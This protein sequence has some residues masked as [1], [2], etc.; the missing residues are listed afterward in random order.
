MKTFPTL[1]KLTSTGAVQQWKIWVDW[2]GN[3]P[4]IFTE[5]GQKDG[6][7]QLAEDLITEGK[8]IGKVNE[9]TP[10]E[11]A[12]AEAQS[13]WEKKLKKSYVQSLEDAEQKK[14]DTNFITGGADPMLAHTY[15][16]QGHKIS[17]PCFVQPKL[18]GHRCIAII[19]DG[20]CTLWSRTR[21][22]ITGVPHINREL[23]RNNSPWG[24]IVLD[25]ELYRHD[26]PFQQLAGYIRSETPKPGSDIVEYWVY[27]VVTEEPFV[28]RLE[29]LNRLEKSPPYQGD[30]ERNRVVVL[31]TF[32]AEDKEDLMTKFGVF[33]D[34]GY[35]GAMARNKKGRYVGKRSYDL[36]KIKEFED[37][38]FKIVDVEEGRG[39]M[40]GCAIFVCETEKGERFNAKMVGSLDNLAILYKKRQTLIGKQV[41]VKFFG[42]SEDGIPRFPVAMRL[43]E[44]V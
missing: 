15:D 42:W 38:E 16:K 2:V 44:D 18:D 1:Y 22:K 31:P 29:R 8:N 43:R 26:I 13:Q 30:P 40:A 20:E 21:K 19:Q 32:E 10:L 6:K 24:T 5:Y 36:Q 27:D 33:L 17:F 4:A 35:E 28:E 34:N 37:A 39:K 41:T 14:I 7:Q 3:N 25:G 23:E 9:T 11:Q 12:E